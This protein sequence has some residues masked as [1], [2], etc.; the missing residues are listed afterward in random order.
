MPSKEVGSYR[1]VVRAVMGKQ[2]VPC[3]DGV[4]PWSWPTLGHRQEKQN[5]SEEDM[6]ESRLEGS[7]DDRTRR[8]KW[9]ELDVFK[10]LD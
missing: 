9:E 10:E 4:S 6:L 5:L 2:R 8:N 1:S 7:F 3:L